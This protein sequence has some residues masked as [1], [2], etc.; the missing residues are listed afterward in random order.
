MIITIKKVL[1]SIEFEDLKLIYTNCVLF[2]NNYLL[3]GNNSV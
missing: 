2:C 1:K 3:D